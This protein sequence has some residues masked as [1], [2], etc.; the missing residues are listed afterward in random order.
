M[1]NNKNTKDLQLEFRL[2]SLG[3]DQKYL[4]GVFKRTPTRISHA[5]CGNAPSLKAKIEKHIEMLEAKANSEKSESHQA[6]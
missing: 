5:F 6:A 2:K 1:K 4:A 3:K